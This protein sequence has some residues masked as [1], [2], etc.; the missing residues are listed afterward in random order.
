M[1]CLRGLFF[2]GVPLGSLAS[3]PFPAAPPHKLRVL[4]SFLPVYCFPANVPGARAQ[5]ENPLPANVEPHD[6]QFARRDLQ[7]LA[8]ADLIFING[9]G[10]EAW[11]QKAFQ[12]SGWQHS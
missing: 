2:L 7:K 10:L 9:L 4:T 3:P 12:N 1:S 8:H 11:L 6:Y 5:V